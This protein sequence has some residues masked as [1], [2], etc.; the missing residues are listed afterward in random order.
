MA[1]SDEHHRLVAMCARWFKRKG[2]A[3]VATE[4]A[5]YGNREQPDVYACRQTCSAIAEIKV[6][7]SDFL[8]DSKKPER[9]NG[10]LGTYRFY[11]C[12]EGMI[13]PSELPAGWGLLYAKGKRIVSIHAPIGNMWPSLGKKDENWSPFA[14]E[15]DYQAE[16]AALFSVA[17][18]L[19]TGNRHTSDR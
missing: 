15:T 19:A 16:R 17:R 10:G 11:L 8:A 12:P 9:H 18:R 3:I 6:S 2:F 4:L 1:T 13:F 5:S 7:R 14:H